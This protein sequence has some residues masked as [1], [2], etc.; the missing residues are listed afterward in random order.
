[1]NNFELSMFKVIFFFLQKC[2]FGNICSSSSKC[3]KHRTSPNFSGG[4][5][6]HGSQKIFQE[7][8]TK[9][10][11]VKGIFVGDDKKEDGLFKK[12]M[13]V[14]LKKE[15]S[16]QIDNSS[17]SDVGKDSNTNKSAFSAKA[18]IPVVAGSNFDF[19][20]I[21]RPT[22]KPLKLGILKNAGT[23]DD[24][25]S[26]KV[27]MINSD[28]II[29]NDYSEDSVF[30]MASHSKKHNRL[31]VNQDKYEI[32]Q[33]SSS[34]ISDSEEIFTKS[35]HKGINLLNSEEK[36]F[37][38]EPSFEKMVNPEN[39]LSTEFHGNIWNDNSFS[40][41]SA[42]HSPYLKLFNS[43]NSSISS[44]NSQ[45]QQNDLNVNPENNISQNTESTKS[46]FKL[47]PP[48][49]N[50]S[51]LSNNEPALQNSFSFSSVSKVNQF[52]NA[53][54][55]LTNTPKSK[56][57][58]KN[59]VSNEFKHVK[60]LDMSSI[61]QNN[62]KPNHVKEI[63][64]TMSEKTTEITAKNNDKIIVISSDDGKN[65]NEN[66]FG[67]NVNSR[68]CNYLNNSIIIEKTNEDKHENIEVANNSENRISHSSVIENNQ[69]DVINRSDS[70]QE[71]LPGASRFYGF[72]EEGST[73]NNNDKIETK[74]NKNTRI[75]KTNLVNKRN[76]KGSYSSGG[77]DGISS[78]P[79]TTIS[80][81][82]SI[83]C[84][85]IPKKTYSTKPTLARKTPSPEQTFDDLIKQNGKNKRNEITQKERSG[86]KRKLFTPNSS[87]EDLSPFK[88]GEDSVRPSEILFNEIPPPKTYKRKRKQDSNTKDEN[89]KK[90]GAYPSLQS[91]SSIYNFTESS[92]T[93][94]D[95][96]DDGK[97]TQRRKSLR[98]AAKKKYKE[99]SSDESDVFET[100]VI[101][102]KKKT[103]KQKTS[104]PPVALSLPD[105]RLSVAEKVSRYVW[106]MNEKMKHEDVVR[107][108]DLESE[109]RLSEAPVEENKSDIS[110]LESVEPPIWLSSSEAGVPSPCGSQYSL[111]ASTQRIITGIHYESL[112][113][114][115]FVELVKNNG[116]TI[117]KILINI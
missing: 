67:D 38:V 76:S 87:L 114:D 49:L 60:T 10:F 31:N 77:W 83:H 4:I 88:P 5:F 39:K 19:K 106:S 20:K 111:N 50:V 94:F 66:N 51:S 61:S 81:L 99:L 16:Q 52:L 59:S 46:V 35:S 18:Q 1:M 72:P 42:P 28:K 117:T 82:R 48:T 37:K 8:A 21:P 12:M 57:E 84:I 96:K 104:P 80:S 110:Q 7:P 58:K 34:V 75:K 9:S 55:N 69:I 23:E 103:Q 113:I 45:I 105:E 63:K 53:N 36:K 85:D 24:N 109:M 100:E 73:S 26:K 25:A 3:M 14:C 13:E 54:K 6:N 17:Y 91:L 29:S 32:S 15:N 44:Q 64:T 62:G 115:Y 47:K 27:S 2:G 41:K 71:S 74:T 11:L 86:K 112:I 93:S 56:S 89:I 98:I 108:E 107:Q 68:Q 97:T 92:P 101:A 43:K 65:S 33:P 70:D 90:K 102:P 79:N 22:H 40:K 30:V 116:K 78:G 95:K